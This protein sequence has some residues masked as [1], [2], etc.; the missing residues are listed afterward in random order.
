MCVRFG[1]ILGI[2]DEIAKVYAYLIYEGKDSAG[3]GKE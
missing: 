1:G 3:G 2:D